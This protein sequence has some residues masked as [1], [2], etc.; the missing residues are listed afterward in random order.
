ME[1]F[2]FYG[3][4][5]DDFQRK[6]GAQSV[7]VSGD[8]YEKDP[9][10][11]VIITTYKRPALLKEA[12]DSALNQVGFEDYQ[13]II[14]DNEGEDISVETETSTLIKNYDSKKIVYYRHPKTVSFKMDNAVRLCRSRYIVFLH[15]DDILESHHLKV[16]TSIAQRYPKARFISCPSVDFID[17]ERSVKDSN[18]SIFRYKIRRCGKAANCLGYYPGWLGALID[19]EAYISTGGM[20]TMRNNIGDFCMVQK[21]HYRYS[22][23]EV[24]S[25]S[26]I[27]YHRVWNGQASS[28]GND[29]WTD[30]YKNEYHY[31]QYVNRKLHPLTYMFWDR[32]SA[33]RILDKAREM[34]RGEY[35][36][37]IDLMQL[38]E[39][40]KMSDN[41]LYRNME[42]KKDISKKQMDYIPRSTASGMRN[43]FE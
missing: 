2:D 39:K 38:V 19:R 22:I 11:T 26:P 4:N 3:E 5:E 9:L 32:V 42:Y 43:E 7:K 33:Y 1:F 16:M 6:F 29:V 31:F 14:A 34:N 25:D 23:H 35:R 24:I 30:L 18:I 12:L 41:S 21:M 10:V 17:G 28:S 36:Y 15:D 13:I 37:D 27:Y 40:S 8:H 20:P